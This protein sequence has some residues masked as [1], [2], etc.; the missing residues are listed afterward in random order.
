[1][2]KKAWS[3]NLQADYQT[4]D[5]PTP[6][7]LWTPRPEF[8]ESCSRRSAQLTVAAAV[9]P[10]DVST[11]RSYARPVVVLIVEAR[12]S[13]GID[14]LYALNTFSFNNQYPLQPL[15]ERVLS[16][17][18]ESIRTV[19]LTYFFTPYA[20]PSTMGGVTRWRDICKA[21]LTLKGLRKLCLC[22]FIAPKEPTLTSFV[23]GALRPLMDMKIDGEFI[24][25]ASWD[26]TSIEQ[27]LLQGD[28]PFEIVRMD[29]EAI[30]VHLI[31]LHL[32]MLR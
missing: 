15:M 32:F 14:M 27:K 23:V 29:K 19:Q 12:Y 18:W 22:P 28:E 7:L 6:D 25:Y 11:L 3:R 8:V 9:M 16:H 26:E 30:H 24:V 20:P 10:E 31:Y 21:L 4:A 2:G 17:R 13:E 5:C 1:M